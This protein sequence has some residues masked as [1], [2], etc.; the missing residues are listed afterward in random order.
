MITFSVEESSGLMTSR[1]SENFS[2]TWDA[3]SRE[4]IIPEN[5]ALIPEFFTFSRRRNEAVF[6]SVWLADRRRDR[7]CVAINEKNPCYGGGAHVGEA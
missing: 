3:A 7:I 2:G 5:E 4:A 6:S 1:T